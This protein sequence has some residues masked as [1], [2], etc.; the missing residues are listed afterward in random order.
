MFRATLTAW[1][2]LVALI[3]GLMIL[4]WSY[5]NFR[6]KAHLPPAL[7]LPVTRLLMAPL[8]QQLLPTTHER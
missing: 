5:G 1:I 8:S 3:G 7:C 2:T 6:H 4:G